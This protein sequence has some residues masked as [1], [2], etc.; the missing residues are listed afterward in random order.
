MVEEKRM[1]QVWVSW[2]TCRRLLAVRGA[3]QRA[4]GRIRNLDEVI[5]ELV[6]FRKRHAV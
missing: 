5:G 2:E 3:L 4:D 6:D 1:A